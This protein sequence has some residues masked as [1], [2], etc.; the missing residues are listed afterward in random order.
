MLV[1]GIG[2][3]LRGDDGAGLAVARRLRERSAPGIRV[4]ELESDAIGLLD[5]WEDARRV[6]LVDCVRTGAAAGT[7]H[8]F[9]VREGLPRGLRASFTTH[10]F[11]VME[12]IDLARTVGRL[13]DRLVVYGIEGQS[14]GTGTPLSPSVAAAVDAVADSVLAEARDQ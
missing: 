12:T 7:I 9:D 4:S 10:A 3:A 2:N 6:V 1:V 8:R 11:D 13:P 14:F 5:V